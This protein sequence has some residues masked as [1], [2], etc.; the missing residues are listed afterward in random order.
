MGGFLAR[1]S[2]Q[3]PWPRYAR[4]AMTITADPIDD[5]ARGRAAEW[6]VAWDGQG[7]H[8]TGTSGDAAGAAWLAHQA[9][10]LGFEPQIEEFLLDRLDPVSALVEIGAEPIEGVPL[11]DAPATGPEGI[12]GT[13]GPAGGDAELG[14]AELSP[15]DVY[16]GEAERIRKSGA[17]RGMIVLCRGE[18]PGLGLLN[19]EQFRQPYGPPAIHLPREVRDEVLAAAGRGAAGRLV[20]HS[21][22]VPA[23]AH[24]IVV[25]LPGRERDRPPLV[26]MTPRSSWWQSTA[27]RG[28]GLVCWLEALRAL[29]TAEPSCDVIFTANS[30]HELNHL[31]LD[32]FLGRRA[33]WDKT[34]TWLHFGAN[35]GA[36]SGKL[37]VMSADDELRWLAVSGLERIGCPADTIAAKTAVPSGE[38]RD[39]HRVG[40]RYLTLVGT[41]ALFHLPQDRWPYAVDLEAITRIAATAAA[42]V[43]ELAR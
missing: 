34:A 18:A 3:D 36:A 13:L 39:I 2:R 29:V 7:I 1:R 5:N 10:S 26:V 12:A 4:G 17:H 27:E 22:R 9:R 32:D 31:G 15:R 42:I 25:T 23:L 35:L 8:R 37:S 30:G 41:N 19:A 11:F 14:V 24:N 38:T 21:R 33:G 43:R 40:G 6:L 20:S 16:S 28:G